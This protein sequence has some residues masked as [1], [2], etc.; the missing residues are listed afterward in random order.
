MSST[1]TLSVTLSLPFLEGVDD[2]PEILL[3]AGE[4]PFGRLTSYT[5]LVRLGPGV[6]EVEVARRVNAGDNA[7]LSPAELE[8]LLTPCEGL[9]AETEM[10]DS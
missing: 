7:S 6:A 5:E 9:L 1:S 8:D 2:P 4:E 10:V 3:P